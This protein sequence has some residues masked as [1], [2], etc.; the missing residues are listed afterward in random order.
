MS[1]GEVNNLE[2]CKWGRTAERF[3][4]KLGKGIVQ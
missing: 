1:G 4:T 3:G 2:K